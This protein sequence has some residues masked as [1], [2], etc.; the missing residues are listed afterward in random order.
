MLSA[1]TRSTWTWDDRALRR[2]LAVLLVDVDAAEAAA[3]SDDSPQGRTRAQT[4]RSRSLSAA[5]RF[6][7]TVLGPKLL[8]DTGNPLREHFLREALDPAQFDRA[9]ADGFASVRHDASTY[10]AAKTK[11]LEYP[12]ESTWMVLVRDRGEA[13][14]GAAMRGYGNS[15]SDSPFFGDVGLAWQT[16]RAVS[17]D[18]EKARDYADQIAA[19]TISATLAAAE[20]TGSWDPALVKTRALETPE[21]WQLTGLKQFVPAAEAADVM[22]VIARSTAGPSLFAVPKS[23]PGVTVTPL[24]VVD[25]TRPLAQIE[26]ADTP[27][28]LPGRRRE[29]RHHCR[30]MRSVRRVHQCPQPQTCVDE[31]IHRATGG[32]RQLRTGSPHDGAVETQLVL[33]VA[34]DAP[35]CRD[36]T[37]SS[38]HRA[39]RC[40]RMTLHSHT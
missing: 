8:A 22:F 5:A 28:V 2:D 33:P 1:L 40:S 17:R 38:D 12:S 3:A 20:Q 7:A 11:Q 14:L 15:L 16:L 30:P 37:G 25:S 27:A 21:G 4:L 19:E 39:P 23:A 13:G 35:G 34:G 29:H 36:S 9:A 18:S 24:D 32:G 10:V 26:L 6:V 31:S